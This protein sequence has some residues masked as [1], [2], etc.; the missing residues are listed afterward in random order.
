MHSIAFANRPIALDNTPSP[1]GKPAQYTMPAV[2]PRYAWHDVRDDYLERLPRLG[3]AE[4]AQLTGIPGLTLA[5]NLFFVTLPDG[6]APLPGARYCSTA[7]PDDRTFNNYLNWDYEHAA[8]LRYQA[9]G[10]PADLLLIRPEYFDEYLA[11]TK[12]A[13]GAPAPAQSI[14]GYWLLP[15]PQYDTVPNRTPR[16]VLVVA[17]QLPDYPQDDLDLLQL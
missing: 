3:T 14:V 5:S 8:A 4:L 17:T 10:A 1:Q 7:A 6:M 2:G 12:T 15:A 16:V 9:N 13:P 11:Q